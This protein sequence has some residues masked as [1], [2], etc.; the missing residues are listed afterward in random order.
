MATSRRKLLEQIGGAGA[1]LG[2]VSL[3]GCFSGGEDTD[4]GN[5]EATADLPS[6]AR[7]EEMTHYTTTEAYWS[8]RF[9]AVQLVDQRLTEHLGLP[10]EPK[11]LELSAWPEYQTEGR[12]GFWSSN[13]SSG[14][15]D[16][17]SQL[18]DT[19]T[20]DAGSNYW[21][22][23]NEEYDEIAREQR[24]A[25]DPDERQELVYEA[26]RILGEERPESQIV[27]NYRTHAINNERIDEDSVVLNFMGIRNIWNLVSMEPLNDEGRTIVTNNF[28]PTD[29][30]NPL[31]QNTVEALRNVWGVE[32]THDYLYQTDPE[33]N[34][35]PWAAEGHDW[36]DETTI[37]VQLRSDLVAHDG[38]SIT[39]EDV[40]FTFD[41]ILETEPPIYTNIVNTVVDTVEQRGDYEVRFVLGE[42]YAPFITST[43]GRVPILPKHYWEEIMADTGNEDTPWE[44]SF[45]DRDLVASGPF[46]KGRWEQGERLE[47]DAFEDHPFAAPNI[48]KRIERNLASRDAEIN[49]LESGEYDTFE[50]WFGSPS[51]L[52][53][54]AEE[55]EHISMVKHLTDTRMAMWSQCERKPLDDV[56]VRQAVNT[57]VMATQQEIISE[58]F[59]D[60]ADPAYSPISPSLEFWHNPDTPVFEGGP[61]AAVELLTDAGYRWDESGHLHLPE[62]ETVN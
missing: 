24:R 28:D 56:A 61:E 37:D 32:L 40:V 1:S 8:E 9:H 10:V 36:V 42:P 22:Y 14:D 45:I 46:I 39:A 33:M 3:A 12:F 44:I 26:Q 18:M 27:Y 7:V 25:T 31:H 62:G 13:W 38:E 50:T 57:V 53:E 30:L 19:F 20:T 48:D 15:G 47:F 5:R 17:D 4:L 60:I 34:P 54:L 29:S 51:D 41:L 6:E 35:Q 16:P 55:N 43:L 23:S 11:G 49:A 21:R 52:N 59:D 2:V 58:I